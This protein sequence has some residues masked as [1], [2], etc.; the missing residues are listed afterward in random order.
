MQNRSSLKHALPRWLTDHGIPLKKPFR[1][2]NPAH[3]D[4]HPSMAYNPKKE[5]VHCFACGVTYDIFDL[6]GQ[7]LGTDNF[8]LELREVN[9]RY[10][11]GISADSAE[12]KLRSAVKV[13]TM[14]MPGKM[15][16][17]FSMRGLS[18]QVVK[19]FCLRVEDGYAV[20]PF[21]Q[22]G[23][24]IAVCRRAV[25]KTAAV[26]YRNSTGAI[27]VWNVETLAQ[28]R[29]VFI[30]EGIFD[31][32]SLEEC[33]YAAAALCGAA[34][35]GK[36]AVALDSLG[37]EK[38]PLA[39]IAAGDSDVAGHRMNEQLKELA[40]KNN[41]LYCKLEMPQGIK[42]VNELLQKDSAR[43]HQLAQSA[44][45]SLACNIEEVAENNQVEHDG[46]S[47]IDSLRKYLLTDRSIVRLSSGL[48]ILDTALGGGFRP[49]LCVLGGVSGVGKTTLMLQLADTWAAQGQPVLYFTTEMS[50]FEL[51][52]KSMARVGQ[53]VLPGVTA[54]QILDAQVP[55]A[56]LEEL[57]LLYWDTVRGNLE[58]AGSG[59]LITPTRLSE[60]VSKFADRYGKAPVVLVDYLQ[61][62]APERSSV[63]DKQNTDRAVVALKQIARRWDTLVLCAS[64]F[65]REAYSQTAEISM[66][67][68]KETGLVEYSA[69]L[70][71]ALQAVMT[72]DKG[73]KQDNTLISTVEGRTVALKVL[74]NRFGAA[75][76]KVKLCYRPEKEVFEPIYS[77]EKKRGAE[78]VTR[79]VMLR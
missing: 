43:L 32:L 63:T 25:E 79:R 14:A 31:A 4:A 67:A 75:G 38:R 39:L 69:D 24:Q 46:I 74:K 35:I 18:D 45:D 5:Y 37:S 27:P 21:L 60:E 6:V 1:C 40:E 58:F 7:E 28:N 41:I 50:P 51:A 48:S 54:R 76:T 77:V 20:L 49:G 12:Q 44:V 52:A 65:N 42:D 59:E 72:E 3:I 2:L 57:L 62:L 56:Q 9:R 61:L 68:F 71:L 29:P 66:S 11:D 36:L 47:F 17:Y 34:N 78:S 19:R 23:R 22:N 15:D 30:T 10:G 64:S 53:N 55:K 8:A 70:L 26:R 33:G 13:S 16:P 73:V